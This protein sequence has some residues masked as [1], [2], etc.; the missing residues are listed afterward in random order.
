MGH[1]VSHSVPWTGPVL[2]PIIASL[3][4][5]L[6][7]LLIFM[8]PTDKEVISWKAW[9]PVIAGTVVIFISFIWDYGVFL[10]DQKIN[11]IF[12]FVTLQKSLI[13]YIPGKFNWVVF[14]VGEL[15]SDWSLKYWSMRRHLHHLKHSK[16]VRMKSKPLYFCLLLL[17]LG[18]TVRIH[19]P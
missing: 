17:F 10:Q 14:A 6:M 2:A 8:H 4:M 5:I 3:T 12:Q 18:S 1:S 16:P 19:N 7:A 13:N 15:L 9:V 11:C